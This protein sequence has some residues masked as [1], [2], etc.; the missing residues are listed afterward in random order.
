[1]ERANAKTLTLSS[2]RSISVDFDHFDVTFPYDYN[3]A[4]CFDEASFT[5]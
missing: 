1:M 4:D 5:A 3:F 2:N